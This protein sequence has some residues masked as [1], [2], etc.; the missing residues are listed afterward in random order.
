MKNKIIET[1]NTWLPEMTDIRR[2]IHAWPELGFNEIKTAAKIAELLNSWGIQTHEGLGKTGVVGRID[3]TQ[4]QGKSIGLRAD[5]DALPILESNSF[6]HASKNHG[7]MH[8]C[9]HDG[10]TT[11]LLAAAKYLSQNRDFKGTIY[12]IFQPAEEGGGG[13]RHMIE[14]GLF[15]KFP[16][17]AVFGMHNWPGIAVGEFGLTDGP[18]MA[19]SNNF[20]I[21]IKGRGAHG[22]M[23]HLGVDP[24][25]VAAQLTCAL[26]TI[27]TRE[28]DPLDAAVISVTQINSGT[29]DNVI[30]DTA[31]MQGTV[32]TLNNRVLDLIERRMQELSEQLCQAMRCT[33][34]FDF[35]RE[36]P[37]TINDKQATELSLTVLQDLVGDDKIN[38]K[39]NPSMGAEDFAFMLEQKPGCYIWIGNGDGTHR[40][41]G[42]G[43][44]PCTLHNSSYDF[45]DNLIP[46]GASYWILLAYKFLD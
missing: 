17:D 21:S 26:Q 30:P 5:I 41:M 31:V 11:M 45:N 42:H 34:K 1:L 19:S 4:G 40:H 13:A 16:M 29:A 46:I 10:H 39:V 22:A 38:P 6:A 28:L 24:V 37:A 2:A 18:I 14:D 36:Y 8:A 3:G 33:V 12:L 32:R 43:A 25:I 44:G 9:G 15:E 7:I 35:S 27:I 20:K 23:P